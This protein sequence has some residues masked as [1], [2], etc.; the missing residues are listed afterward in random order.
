MIHLHRWVKEGG[1]ASS[2]K[3]NLN[4]HCRTPLLRDFRPAGW[5]TCMQYMRKYNAEGPKQESKRFNSHV[6]TKHF[7]HLGIKFIYGKV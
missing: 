6:K 5:V 7:A 1:D 3:L 4:F 2:V